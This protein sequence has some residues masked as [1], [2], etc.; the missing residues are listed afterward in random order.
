MPPPHRQPPSSYRTRSAWAPSPRHRGAVVMPE[1]P[2]HLAARTLEQSVIDHHRDRRS[3]WQQPVHDQIKH[4]QPDRVGTPA[5]GSD[6]PVRPGVMP[7]SLQPDTQQHPT[8]RAPSS[9]RDQPDDHRVER[10]E[11]G[12][13]ETGP[14]D[15]QQAG[16]R[17]RY[18]AVGKHRRTA[19]TR[20]VQAPSMLP[21]F[22]PDSRIPDTGV[23]PT[24]TNKI[25]K[26]CETRA[27]V[28][29]PIMSSALSTT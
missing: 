9:L 11:R 16:Q 8:H 29:V 12:R 28:W 10:G 27:T 1:H 25:K 18:G 20:A 15:R 14:E 21:S 2:E 24:I 6:Q 5:G 13:G 7:H 26:I 22:I 23:S 19:L 3:L 17:T 4:H